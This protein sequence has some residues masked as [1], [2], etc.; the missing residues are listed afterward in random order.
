MRFID[1]CT[2]NYYSYILLGDLPFELISPFL[3]LEGQQ[4]LG[5]ILGSVTR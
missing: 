3:L 4:D 2:T 1:A 5:N